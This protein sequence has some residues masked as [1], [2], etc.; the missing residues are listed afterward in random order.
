MAFEGAALSAFGLSFLFTRPGLPPPLIHL[1]SA[2]I[3]EE[4]VLRTRMRM[5]DE[6]IIMQDCYYGG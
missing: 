2:R 4:F 1:L 5:Q 6:Q 3:R